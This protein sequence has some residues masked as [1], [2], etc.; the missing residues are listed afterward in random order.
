MARAMNVKKRQEA[1][2]AMRKRVA[3]YAKK[4]LQI[5]KELRGSF[6]SQSTPLAGKA[7]A[8]ATDAWNLAMSLKKI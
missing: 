1:L 3:T 5:S 2:K 4:S 7:L 8:V 6:S